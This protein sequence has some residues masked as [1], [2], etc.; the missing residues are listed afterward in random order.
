MTTFEEAIDVRNINDSP[1]NKMSHYSS[2]STKLDTGRLGDESFL[3]QHMFGR[4]CLERHG[5]RSVAFVLGW[6]SPI[7]VS[8]VPC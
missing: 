6:A 4:Q 3:V 5:T 8:V 7:F 1:A 2:I